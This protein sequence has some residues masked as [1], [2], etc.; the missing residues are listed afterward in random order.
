MGKKNSARKRGGKPCAE[1]REPNKITH[2]KMI[3]S[4]LTFVRANAINKSPFISFG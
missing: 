1:K 4:F 3:R 2:F